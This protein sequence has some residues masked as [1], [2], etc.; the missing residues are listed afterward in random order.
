MRVKH[1]DN[2]NFS[3]DQYLEVHSQI[4][5]SGLAGCIHRMKGYNQENLSEEHVIRSIQKNRKLLNKNSTKVHPQ[6]DLPL[7]AFT[8]SLA[9]LTCES[10]NTSVFKLSV[11]FPSLTNETLR[12]LRQQPTNSKTLKSHFNNFPTQL[13][14]SKRNLHHQPRYGDDNQRSTTTTTTNI[15]CYQITTEGLQP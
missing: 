5:T 8:G 10:C 14:P 15:T 11:H 3:D 13:H 7:V 6:S 2:K 9:Y 1:F 4:G 12:K